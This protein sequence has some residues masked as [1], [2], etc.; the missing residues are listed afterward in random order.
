MFRETY[1]A[2]SYLVRNVL[3]SLITGKFRPVLG[4]TRILAT[5]I[6]TGRHQCWW[7]IQALMDSPDFF[8]KIWNRMGKV[9]AFQMGI[10]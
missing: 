5:T 4:V 8:S 10:I 3:V 6:S 2:G 9:V 1:L 7:L